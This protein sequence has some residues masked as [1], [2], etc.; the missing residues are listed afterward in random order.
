MRSPLPRSC[1][2]VLRRLLSALRLLLMRQRRIDESREQR[3]AVTWRRGEFGMELTADE[4]RVIWHLDHF[5]QRAVHGAACHLQAG[6]LQSV[7][8]GIVD[9]IA[10]P[11]TLDNHFLP[12]AL[13][14]S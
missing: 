3:M 9:F 10:M 4:P 7:Q 13:V 5:H 2:Y 14:G 11:V 6:A 8:V 1:S 12:I